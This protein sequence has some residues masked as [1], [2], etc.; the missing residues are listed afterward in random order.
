MLILVH[1]LRWLFFIEL[2]DKANLDLSLGNVRVTQQ[3]SRNNLNTLENESIAEGRGFRELSI[4]RKSTKINTITIINS[5][6]KHKQVTQ[7]HRPS[8]TS[9]VQNEGES[10]ENHRTL[11][12]TSVND[13]LNRVRKSSLVTPTT[14]PT[15]ASNYQ[16]FS[17]HYLNIG[18]PRQKLS[19]IEEHSLNLSQR[20]SSQDSTKSSSAPK[21]T[22]NFLRQ[23]FFFLILIN[24]N[25]FEFY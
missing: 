14:P 9:I 11:S 19:L 6:N 15:P 3:Y 10:I 5:N 18:S 13:N 4:K 1:S 22:N 16:P 23:V 8:L 17:S 21:A 7:Y 20:Q 24:R 2:K 12:A 25:L